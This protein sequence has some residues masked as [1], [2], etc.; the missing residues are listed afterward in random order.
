MDFETKLIDYITAQ[1]YSPRRADELLDALGV[2]PDTR[3]D[4]ERTLARLC[5]AGK[6]RVSKH[7]RILPPVPPPPTGTFMGSSRGFG[8]VRPADSAPGDASGDIFIP[9]R[10][11]FGAIDG[12]TVAYTVSATGTGERAEGRV[13]DIIERAL[14]HVIGAITEV[15]ESGRM[16]YAVQPDSRKLSFLV[17]VN[18]AAAV[19]ARRGDKVEALITD[20]P[21]ERHDALGQ[22]TTV[23]GPADSTDANY[24]AVLHEHGIKTTFDRGLTALADRLS[25][26]PVVPDG[27]LDLRD[28]VIFTVDGADSKDLDDAISVVRTDEGFELGVHIADVS[29]Y[30]TEDDPL[31]REAFARG[32]SVYFADQVVP[33]LPKALSNGICSL[34]GGVDRYALSAFIELDTRGNILHTTLARTIINSCVR[35]VYSE[36]NDIIAHGARSQYAQKYAPLGDSLNDALDLYRVL[37]A[38]SRARGAVELETVEAKIIVD[39]ERGPIDIVKRERGVSE[40]IIEQF[41]LAAN[42]AVAGWLYGRKFPCV[43]RTHEQP[44]DEKLHS[45]R[46]F[47]SNAGLD[48][49]PLHERPVRAAALQSVL[50][51]AKRKGIESIISTVLLRSMMKAR[52]SPACSPHFGLAIERYCHFT[53]PIRRYP[54]LATHRIICAVLD[55]SLQGEKLARM[56]R[57]AAQ[58]AEASSE[59]EKRAMG[60]ERE[61]EDLYRCVFMQDKI[62]AR[63]PARVS[64]L[65]GFGLFCELDNTCEGLVPVNT[66]RG[67]FTFNERNMTLQSKYKIYRLGDQ[68]RV[69]IASVDLAAKRI[70]M[71]LDD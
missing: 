24:V 57:F 14:T 54:D 42:E 11:T 15:R 59:N 9:A 16:R 67:H 70:Y 60:A 31:D 7:G 71:E 45:L 56:E 62:G 41:M 65:T 32:T 4:A 5:A 13:T 18:N 46:V 19:G 33:M 36:L 38:K 10:D 8:F 53:S 49:R 6:V 28:A 26:T 40:R 68:V 55:G 34:N 1:D 50:D 66:M 30:V 22:I 2:A 29:Y 47:A 51:Q 48:I 39:D 35:G 63:Y 25:R 23:F 12:D 58:A 3:A 27:R 61:I 52:Y 20:Y 44:N 17:Y 43:Y 69:K 21:D 64:S 37:A